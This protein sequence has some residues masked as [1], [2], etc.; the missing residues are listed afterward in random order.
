MTLAISMPDHIEP[1]AGEEIQFQALVQAD[2]TLVV[3]RVLHVEPSKKKADKPM[4]IVEWAKKWGGS[5]KLEAGETRES[6]R[7]SYAK[8]KFG[9]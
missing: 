8:E 9:L 7:D 5:M 2:G 4:N 1:H 6:L 3:T